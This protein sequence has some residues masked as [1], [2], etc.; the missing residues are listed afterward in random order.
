MYRGPKPNLVI[1][2]YT[3]ERFQARRPRKVE[4]VIYEEKSKETHN[5]LSR[6]STYSPVALQYDGDI[7]IRF[8]VGTV[9]AP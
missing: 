6:R 2:R 8:F 1:A 9:V 5:S 4:G 3:S 7:R